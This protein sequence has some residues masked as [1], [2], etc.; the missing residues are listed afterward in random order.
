MLSIASCGGQKRPEGIVIG[1]EQL[2]ATEPVLWIGS[3]S[4]PSNST[5]LERKSKNQRNSA[6]ELSG[7]AK[8]RILF[9]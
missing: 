7:I 4:P 1:S 3:D 6:I 2:Y 8:Q 5:E 9:L